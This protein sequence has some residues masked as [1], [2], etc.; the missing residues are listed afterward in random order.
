MTNNFFRVQSAIIAG[1]QAI[2]VQVECAQSRRLPY[3]QIIGGS[4]QEAAEL[5]ERVMA[6]L[7][8]S[9]LRIP[10]RRITVQLQPAAHGLPLENLD[11]AV[12][13]AI[14]GSSGLIPATRVENLLICGSLG[15]DGSL[16]PIGNTAA[17]RRLLKQGGYSSALLPWNGSEILEEERLCSGGGFRTLSELVEFARGGHS[18]KKCTLDPESRPPPPSQ[19]WNR[20]EGQV[21]AKRMLEVAAAGSH[22][23]L[24][25]GPKAARADLLAHALSILLPELSETESEEVRNVYALAGMGIWPSRPFFAFASSTGLPPLL[26][27][28][29]LGKVEEFLL[30]HRGVFFVDRVCEREPLL[31]PD[32]LGPM[33]TGKI[34]ARVGKRRM[35]I[36]ADPLVVATTSACA[37]GAQG[38]QKLVCSCRPTEARR[39]R[40]RWRRLLQYPFDLYLP[41][42]AEKEQ[43]SAASVEDTLE[44]RAERI[45]KARALMVL[46]QGKANGRLLEEEVLGVKQW[47]DSVL[48]LAKVLGHRQGLFLP[49]AKVALT[50]SDLRGSGLVEEQDLFEARHYFPERGAGESGSKAASSSLPDTKSIAIP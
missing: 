28:R 10:A 39:H 4:G 8:S 46:R 24:L 27:D 19:V 13:V 47:K 23:V 36:P 31:F 50:L 49:L 38:D 17:L 37:C 40:E 20:I 25:T 33:L 35:E 34:Q 6:A 22:H 43:V 7:D 11:L 32:L 42:V 14:L 30:A 29:R 15:L 9:R 18:G 48:K 2:P 1:I 5:R 3:L 44:V 26:Q 16:R 12:A 21:V 45:Q 41:L